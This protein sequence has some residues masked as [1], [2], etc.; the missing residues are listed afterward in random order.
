ML[1][2]LDI[3]VVLSGELLA[4]SLSTLVFAFEGIGEAHP[5]EV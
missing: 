5:N 2:F 4:L 3:I 1:I